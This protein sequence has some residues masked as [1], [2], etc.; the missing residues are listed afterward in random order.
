MTNPDKEAARAIRSCVRCGFCTAT[1]PTHVLLG[2]EL[3]GPRGRIQLMK[4]MLESNSSP[5]AEVVAHIDRCLSCLSCQTTCPSGVNYMHL[6]DEARAHIARRH[7][8]PMVD[9][10]TRWLL[11]SILP[12]PNRLRLVIPLAS[13]ARPIAGILNRYHLTK[14]VAAMINL[15]P[16]RLP[17]FQARPVSAGIRGKVVLL[18]GCAEPVFDPGIQVAAAR[19][20]ARMGYALTAAPGEQCCGAL[21]HHMGHEQAALCAA[22]ANIDAWRK[23]DD[24]TAII[25][26]TSG[27][28]TVVKTYGHMLRN[29]ADYA[30]IAAYISS[31][32]VDISEFVAT[33][34]FPPVT[35]PTTGLRVAYHAACS[36]QHGQNIRA[37]PKALLNQAGFA[38]L[39]IAEGHLCC[40]SA[41]TYN[42]LQPDIAN[43]LRQRKLDNIKNLAPDVVVTGNIGCIV[44]LRSEIPVIH[45][46]KML[47]WATGGPQPAEL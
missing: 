38:T 17:R 7:R 4:H 25:I 12:Y 15:A 10:L 36:L 33:A 20:L 31:I 2:N 22:R 45:I 28:G 16:A 39:D 26:T 6:V 29:D 14:P 32:T 44:Q 24:L 13:A 18:R 27:C 5:T 35:L 47:D 41:G 23:I 3:D 19:L 21:V 42:I 11:A 37:E 9:R 1:C 43:K 34:G 46:V 40:G 30:A 8:R